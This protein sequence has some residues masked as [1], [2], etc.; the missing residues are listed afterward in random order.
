MPSKVI[1]VDEAEHPKWAKET[2][3]MER[4][5]NP[6]TFLFFRHEWNSRSEQI[7]SHIDSYTEAENKIYARKCSVKEIKSREHRD[8]CD[9]YHIQ[10]SNRLSLVSFGIFSG[11]ELL[12]VLSLGRHNRDSRVTV[13]DRLCF[14]KG[15]RVVG[16]ASR[17]FS[18]AKKWALENGVYSILS[19]S[20][21]RMSLGT[22]YERLGFELDCVLPPDYFYVKEGDPEVAFSKQSQSKNA[23]GCPRSVT[24]KEWAKRKGLIQVFDAGKKR[25]ILKLRLHKEVPLQSRRQGYYETKK[26]NPRVLYYQSSYELR[27]A[28]M[29]DEMDEVDSY[30]SQH[31][32]TMD[33][34]ERITDFIVTWN[35]GSK[36][37]LEIKPDRRL[38]QFKEQIEDNKEYAI[39]NGWKFQIW[40]EKELGFESEYFATKWAD[41]FISKITQVDFV[42][43]RKDRNLYKSKK[44]YHTHI[45]T[46]KVSVYCEYCNEDHNPLR[47]TYDKNIARNG[48]YICEREG[49]RI[50]GSRPKPH[51]KKINPYESEGKKEC[52]G[53]KQVLPF[54][55]YG[56][57][58]CRSDGYASKCK[59]CR[60]KAANEKYAQKKA[61]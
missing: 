2:L 61:T 51:L 1:I 56:K 13:L 29:L 46:D 35:D 16:G 3:E 55:E 59:E 25:W 33:G 36:T 39:R 60:R 10:G 22:V 42:K 41:E 23:T 21:E 7:I 52:L 24:E 53:C 28:T 48:R 26:A 40:T 34:R 47:L 11:K 37:I 8:F 14:K 38:D 20:D 50:A 54:S 15:W 4:K 31:T 49:G 6:E 44:Y 32:F 27:A 57:D 5:A 45:A 58:K 18:A 9:L 19:F 17:L 30:I 12:G 43:E